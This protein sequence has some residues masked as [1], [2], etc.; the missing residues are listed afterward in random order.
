MNLALLFSELKRVSNPHTGATF[1]RYTGG[2]VASILRKQGLEEI[3]ARVGEELHMQY[4]LSFTPTPPTTA[5]FHSIHVE[6][7][8]RPELAVRT[9]AGYWSAP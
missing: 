9:R 4:L 2:Q 5:S 6:V 7:K 8:D 1:A 3:L